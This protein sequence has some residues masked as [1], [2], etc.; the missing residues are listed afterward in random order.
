MNQY[1]IAFN[2][3][4]LSPRNAASAL[5]IQSSGMAISMA[6]WLRQKNYPYRS[7]VSKKS[8]TQAFLSVVTTAEAMEK[9]KTTF[10]E[11]IAEVKL[12]KENVAAVFPPKPA[13]P[14]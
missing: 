1:T 9:L 8:D 12:E 14:A 7:M 10:A 11:S 5:E 13:K 4:A 3:I 6:A 2:R